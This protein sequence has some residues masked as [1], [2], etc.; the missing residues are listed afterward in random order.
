MRSWA[1]TTV[2]W[3]WRSIWRIINLNFHMNSIVKKLLALTSAAAIFLSLIPVVHAVKAEPRTA[4]IDA[5][6]SSLETASVEERSEER[7][8]G[9]EC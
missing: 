7:R 1:L 2:L 9:K 5:Q 8:V 6:W 4:V 3:A